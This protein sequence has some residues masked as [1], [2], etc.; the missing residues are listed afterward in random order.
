[1]KKLHFTV[2]VPKSVAYNRHVVVMGLIEGEE[3]GDVA[4]IDL[5]EPV[6]DEILRNVREAYKANVIHADLSEHNIIIKP[7]GEVLII[8]WPQWVDL[9]HPEAYNLIRRTW[10]TSSNSSRENSE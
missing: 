3:L 8:D 9:N 10:K 6:L 7:N 2:E 5:P 4:D 1:M